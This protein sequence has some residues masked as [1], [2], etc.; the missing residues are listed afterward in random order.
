MLVIF[1]LK[2]GLIHHSASGNV[3]A[4]LYNQEYIPEIARTP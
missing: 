2:C 3:Y 4:L 1:P